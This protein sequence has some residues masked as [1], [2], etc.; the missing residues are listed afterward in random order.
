MC[1]SRGSP[2]L[3]LAAQVAHVDA[4]G[5]GRLARVIAPDALED[6]G[7]RE[8]L[9]GVAHE[10]LEQRVLSPRQLDPAT[11]A[12]DVARQR[13]QDEVGEPDPLRR[14]FDASHQRSQAGVE[15][16]ESERLDEVVVR[17]GV[18]TIDAVGDRVSCGQHEDRSAVARF[19]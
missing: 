14:R 13:I 2:L 18:K 16:R 9:I 5:V 10:Q 7:A 19:P 8:D 15:L 17:A 1:S 4:Q 12:I 6:G 11:A 3:C